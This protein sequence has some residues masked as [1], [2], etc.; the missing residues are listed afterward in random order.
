MGLLPPE[1]IALQG[2]L[3]AACAG[4][5]QLLGRHQE[6]HARLEDALEAVDDPASSQAAALMVSLALDAFFR[7]EHQDSRAWA[8][9]ALAVARPLGD[10]PVTAAAAG[11]LAL[12]CAFVGAIDEG[13]ASC[14]E[15]AGLIDAMSDAQLAI[16]LDAIAYLTG[17][18]SHLDHFDEAVVHGRRGLAVARATAQ[19]ALLARCCRWS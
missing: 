13:E 5:E 9:R 12:A 15:A 4:L 6:A 1:A 7:K 16:R 19:G 2:R 17:A 8:A 10:L 3:T 18:E 14:A 11:I